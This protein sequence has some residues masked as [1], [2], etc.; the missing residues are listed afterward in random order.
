MSSSDARHGSY[1]PAH[2]LPSWDFIAGALHGSGPL[3]NYTAALENT[4]CCFSK[5][6]IFAFWPKHTTH[7]SAA[8]KINVNKSSA[9]ISCGQK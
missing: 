6:L 5:S 4:L 8:M 2:P 9:V 3:L 7:F 1:G